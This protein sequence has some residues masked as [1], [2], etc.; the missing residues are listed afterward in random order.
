M[1]YMAAV[2]LA[3]GLLLCGCMSSE[4]VVRVTSPDGRVDAIL[5]ET[6]CGAPCSFGYE[7]G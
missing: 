1:K 3:F 7:V 4:E 5:V 2:L 6:N